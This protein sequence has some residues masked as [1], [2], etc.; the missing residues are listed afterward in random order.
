MAYNAEIQSQQMPNFGQA[1]RANF[2]AY[3]NQQDDLLRKFY[4][5]MAAQQGNPFQAAEVPKAGAFLDPNQP[6]VGVDN[7]GGNQI[8]AGG[9]APTTGGSALLDSEMNKSSL[10]NKLAKAK[11]LASL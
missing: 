5:A 9:A 1:I 11:L 7:P 6:L 8:P 10:G 4:T 3:Q 2:G